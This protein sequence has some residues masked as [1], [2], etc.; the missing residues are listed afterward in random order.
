[1]HTLPIWLKILSNWPGRFIAS[2]TEDP[3]EGVSLNKLPDE[4]LLEI[5]RRTEDD[6]TI[7][8]T[9]RTY[10]ELRRVTYGL[11]RK[12]MGSW[13][14]GEHHLEA[15]MDFASGA[16]R[17]Q[18]L[19]RISNHECLR[20]ARAFRGR[21]TPG[22]ETLEFRITVYQG[23]NVDGISARDT[24]GLAAWQLCLALSRCGIRPL[25]LQVES[26]LEDI[27]RAFALLRQ[28][29]ASFVTIDTLVFEIGSKHYRIERMEHHI[30]QL[31]RD[32]LESWPILKHLNICFEAYAGYHPLKKVVQQATTRS[33]MGVDM[34]FFNNMAWSLDADHHASTTLHV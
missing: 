15:W 26:Q 14:I 7:R 2:R 17:E 13:S 27:E 9:T 18:V 5:A 29:L 3:G 20:L 32:A 24:C 11:L 34:A 10:K 30:E 16:R 22:R 4:I 23:S 31:I 28:G 19:F 33:S 25:T 8:C 1:M 12:K 21:P 6:A